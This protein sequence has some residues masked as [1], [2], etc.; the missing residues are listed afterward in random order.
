[1]DKL[2]EAFGFKWED[3]DTPGHAGEREY[4]MQM[5]EVAQQ[6]KITLE[7]FK[8]YVPRLRNA[9]EQELTVLATKEQSESWLTLLTFCLPII[10]IIRKWYADRREI[11]LKARLENY[12]LLESFFTAREQAIAEIQKRINNL[13]S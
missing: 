2:A 8:E 12:M 13:K 3:L 9:V 11:M 6:N 5:L 1:M 10:G 4:L 7:T